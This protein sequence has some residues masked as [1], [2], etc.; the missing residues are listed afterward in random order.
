M[1]V[2]SETHRVTL[3]DCTGEFEVWPIEKRQLHVTEYRNG[4]KVRDE[5]E[6][7]PD[8][9]TTELLEYANSVPLF[10]ATFA[11]D[12]FFNIDLDCGFQRWSGMKSE[13]EVRTALRQCG[14][15]LE[16]ARAV[17][18]AAKVEEHSYVRRY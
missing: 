13:S 9:A 17:I 14:F 5:T 10:A 6:T 18:S 16:E 15:S 12:G 2:I 8:A 7:K 4:V 1:E 3:D 11:G